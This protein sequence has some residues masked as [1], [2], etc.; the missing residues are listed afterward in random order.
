M[1]ASVM[2]FPLPSAEK[3]PGVV[4]RGTGRCFRLALVLCL[5]VA[6]CL[7]VYWPALSGPYLFDDV[8]ML[9]HVVPEDG[10]FAT[11][12]S[13]AWHRPETRPLVRLTF[14]VEATLFGDQ[15]L[16]RRCGNV[17]IHVLSG[18]VLFD[19]VVQALCARFPAKRA[20]LHRVE[21][22]D[23][24][25]LTLSSPGLEFFAFQ[26]AA[27]KAAMLAATL[28]MLHPLQSSAVANI[29]Q[30]CESLMGLFFFIC[31]DCFVR[32]RRTGNNRWLVL[33]SVSFVLGLWSKTVIVTVLPVALLL[34]R[35]LFS[36]SWRAVIRRNWLLVLLPAV[37]SIIAVWSMLPGLL[38]GESNVGFGGHAPPVL[39]H[40]SAQSKILW[41]YV[42]QA[43]WPEWISIDHGLRPPT[44]WSDHLAWIVMTIVVFTVTV[45]LSSRGHW[46]LCFFILTPLSVL[47]LTSSVIPTADLWVDHRMYV[48]MASLCAAFVLLLRS[49]LRKLFGETGSE[50]ALIPIV[51]LLVLLLAFRTRIRAEDYTSG[52]RM[53][54]AAVMENPDNDRAI[55]NLIGFAREVRRERAILSP[56]LRDALKVAKDRAIVPT[57]VLGRIGEQFAFS[58]QPQEAIGVLSQAIS[59]D[60]RHFFKGYRDTRRMHERAAMQVSLGLALA[61]IGRPLDALSAVNASF[62]Y[63][64]GSADARAF[65]GSL[66]MQLGDLTSARYNFEQALSLKPGWVDVEADLA[67]LEQIATREN[68]V[69]TDVAPG[70]FAR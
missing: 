41:L 7:L 39:L 67:R 51:G 32:L 47:S 13:L 49:V 1:S 22:A 45:I 43:V 5:F 70:S 17:L 16:V 10:L 69:P 26:S 65:A 44:F 46:G 6:A 19:L 4:A 3:E 9:D 34:D 24:E 27:R 30:R 23:N 20:S 48:P 68:P 58:G 15:P 59:L 52:V 66:S 56:V 21:I 64:I 11:I 29:A 25:G 60:D 28:W 36:G 33:A 57:V 61:A 12:A 14:D 40:L 35:A 31:L 53:W 37:G 55:Q 62:E 2:S 63:N 54:T 42:F 50:R 8:G 18:L 38:R